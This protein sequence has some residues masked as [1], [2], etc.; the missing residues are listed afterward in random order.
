MTGLIP[1]FPRVC[2]AVWSLPKPAVTRG[3]PFLCQKVV[4]QIQEVK[5]LNSVCKGLSFLGPVL[6]WL[7]PQCVPGQSISWQPPKMFNR[8]STRRWMAFWGRDLLHMRKSSSSGGSHGKNWCGDRGFTYW[9]LMPIL[10][11]D[12]RRHPRATLFF[13]LEVIKPQDDLQHRQN[14]L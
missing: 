9:S 14:L 8:I 6:S 5:K 11:W 13:F 4:S 12:R 3:R 7:L 1:L 10:H 2:W